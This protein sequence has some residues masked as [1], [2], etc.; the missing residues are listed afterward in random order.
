VGLVLA[1]ILLL[2]L[3]MPA[4]A[5]TIGFEY[6]D[7]TGHNVQGAFLQFYHAAANPLLVYGYP[8][9][10]EFTGLD[11]LRVQYFQRARFEFRPDLPQGM[12]VQLTSLGVALYTPSNPVEAFNPLACRF[13]AETGYSVCY[14]FREFFE[15]N[16]GV[17]QFGQPVSAFEY[18][19]DTIVQYFEKSRLEWQP[20]RQP[21]QRVV[22]ADLGRIYFD[23]LG[24]DPGLLPPVEPLNAIVEPAVLSMNVDAFVWKAVT[25]A[26]DQQTIY[27]I[28]RDQRGEPL[29][30]ANCT[31][32]LQW[33]GDRADTAASRT[34]EYGLARL[35]FSFSGQLQGQLILADISC[36]YKGITSTTSTSF[37][38]W[39]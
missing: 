17:D 14:E 34:D 3:S 26:S 29:T 21:G 5:Q 39:Y 33:P 38:V 32:H 30:D 24:E 18:R 1:L 23:A 8:I 2:A 27:I 28:A 25:L 6:F 10:E 4:H 12:Q 9:T 16:G 15:A 20:W 22:I 36:T 13:F 37:R 7:Q 19:Q 35:A 11:G 31:T